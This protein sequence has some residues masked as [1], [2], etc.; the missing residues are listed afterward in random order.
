MEV[1]LILVLII[2]NG[3]LVMSEMSLVSSKKARLLQMVEKG[4]MGAAKAL[5]LQEKPAHFLS[6]IQV[7]ITSVSIL[8]GIIGEKSLVGP[9]TDFFISMG[10]QANIAHD[11]SSV[12]VITCL[13]YLSVIFGEIIPKRIA[14][15]LSDKIAG[16]IS[17]PMYWLSTILLPLVWIF[18]KSS[19]IIMCIFGLD[20]I[21]QPS[22]TNEEVKELMS[23]G[24][25]DGTFHVSEEQI[26]TNVLHMDEKRVSAIMTHRADITFI[27]VKNDF[28]ENIEKI[29]ESKF[30]RTVL[31]EEH[32]DNILGIVH[33]TDILSLIKSGQPFDLTQ[34]VETV[35]YLPETVN[36]IQVLECFKRKKKEVAI[37]VNER[38][39]NIGMIT[40]H[41]IM[42][43][44]V[45]NIDEEDSSEDI[46]KKNENSWLVE[47]STHL[48]KLEQELN[49]EKLEVSHDIYTIAGFILE[50]AASIPEVGYFVE[51]IQ[52]ENQFKFEVMEMQKNTVSKVQITK[53]PIVVP[54]PV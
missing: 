24:S 22:V 13:T 30:T 29:I 50:H 53:K 26:V 11:V 5:D 47:G 27:D 21:K 20:K 40:L 1:I 2:F 34:H 23:Q 51:V 25:E 16:L 45:G 6:T 48:E 52:G 43:A 3:L 42:S 9:V 17:I 8:S 32:I 14:L 28:K 33:V 39:E 36:A 41:D 37:I 44:M 54:N 49:I 12:L 46:E 35:L 7:G 4:S 15:V 10:M 19:E 18:T 38:G 31:I